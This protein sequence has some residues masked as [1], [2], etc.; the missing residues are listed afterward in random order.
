MIRRHVPS[1]LP[2]WQSAA[3]LAFVAAACI[4]QTGCGGGS[5]GSSAAPSNPVVASIA[6][7]PSSPT[8]AANATEQFAATAKDSSGNTIGGVTFTW[9]SSA[10]GVATINSSG[11][12]TGVAVGTTQ[13]TASA[14]G[15]TSPGDTLTV[16][17]VIATIA[18]TPSSPTITANATEQFTATAKDSSG[19]TIGGV[20]FTWASSA[21]GVATINSATG[22]ATGVSAGTAQ[23]TAAAQ[24]VTSA[25]DT[26]TV[27]ATAV[28]TS[29]SF[30]AL[31]AVNDL[32]LPLS[33]VTVSVLDQSGNLDSAA[34]G[35]V[36]VALGANPAAATLSGTL[37]ETVTSG[38]ATFSNLVLDFPGAGYTLTASYSGVPT[39]TSAAFTVLASHSNLLSVNP[40]TT[41]PTDWTWTHTGAS[42]PV[43]AST[44][45]DL[46]L[47]TLVS[48]LDNQA[49]VPWAQQPQDTL[50]YSN[51][52]SAP[53]TVEVSA[54]DTTGA[55]QVS[56]LTWVDCAN[57]DTATS[58]PMAP[59]ASTCANLTLPESGSADKFSGFADPTMRKDPATGLVWLGYS[60]PH[61]W[62]PGVGNGTDVVDLHVT[63]SSDNGVT[64]NTPTDL[65]VS[66][67]TT[68]PSNGD[69]AYTSNEV[70]SIL[71]GQVNGQTGETWFS[72]H[73]NYYVD[74]GS[75]IIDSLV[76]HSTMVLNWASTPTGLG[77]APASQTVRFAAAGLSAGI[78]YD[79][80]LTT[81][82]PSLA[83]C[84]QWAEPALYMKSGNLYMVLMCKY[85]TSP[86]QMLP[87][88]NFYGV[89]ETT[90]NLAVT[91]SL[92]TWQYN[93]QLAGTADAALL[94]G[95]QFFYE[96]D[97]ATRADGSI[98]A[99]V[100]PADDLPNPS[101]PTTAIQ[102]TYG[103]QALLV[104]GL[105][106]GN[107]GMA[108]DA[109]GQLEVLASI[110]ASDLGPANGDADSGACTYEPQASNGIVF[111][112][113]Y[114]PD[115]RFPSTGYWVGL[116][117]TYVMP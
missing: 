46:V 4:L 80:N 73:L 29:I 21:A 116:F 105:D 74:Q 43:T 103:C 44:T 33:A 17:P 99:I 53:Y 85:G 54:Q 65:W 37:Q 55:T 93:G 117:N 16:T 11:L 61:V 39:I 77:S 90:P 48:Q 107:I 95:H 15:V 75:T 2:S 106:K 84:Q 12:A 67:Q 30:S 19:N 27:T 5:S 14:Q 6:V 112:R 56:T 35:S 7:T 60:W 87:G 82:D 102:Y 57:T 28:A 1:G 49:P 10:A 41:T 108:L 104:K 88:H 24:G 63:Y 40:E 45:G 96:L 52:A 23:I 69:T 94:E 9:A 26:L 3:L 86:A 47:S 81:V 20:T 113:V 83:N 58:Q 62:N 42:F 100:S 101:D 97:L 91:P 8:I 92:W 38:K 59:T 64:W 76:P 109:N 36:T 115:T 25:P 13:I 89:F 110:T 114:S 98:V 22:L 78:P 18:V 31:A 70:L 71:P 50:A 111:V 66:Q 72:A 34:T 32:G 51:L 68:D 79:V